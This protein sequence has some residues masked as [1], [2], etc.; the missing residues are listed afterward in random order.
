MTPLSP[1]D[2]TIAVL[3]GGQSRR[4]GQEKS[5]VSLRGKPM[6]RH[7]LE[8]VQRLGAPVILLTN[9][10]EA[11]QTLGVSLFGDVQPL[12]GSLVGLHSALIHS[13]TPYTLCVAC[14]MPLLNVDLLRHLIT[15]REGVDAVVPRIRQRPESLHAVYHHRCLAAIESQ[16]E[17]EEMRISRLFDN[18]RVRYVSEAEVRSFDPDLRSFAN[19]NTPEE[20]AAI[21]SL[22]ETGL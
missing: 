6:I 16:I 22:L 15:L 13:S 12:R 1:D 5:F 10:P 19:A 4:M 21:E 20:L 9:Q 8:R 14:D 18:L 17:R 3:A 7:T 2:L 11:Y